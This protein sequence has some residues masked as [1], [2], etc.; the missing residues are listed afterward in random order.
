[1]HKK[2]IHLSDTCASAT[3]LQFNLPYGNYFGAFGGCFVAE[4]LVQ[5][6]HKLAQIIA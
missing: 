4:T 3:L 2:P 1:M 6:H 5:A